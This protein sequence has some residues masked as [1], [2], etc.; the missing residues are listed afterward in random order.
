IWEFRQVADRVWKEIKPMANYALFLKKELTAVGGSWVKKVELDQHLQHLYC[1]SETDVFCYDMDGNQ[2]FKLEG[3]HRT[4]IT[5]CRY[6]LKARLLVTSSADAE[7]KVWSLTGGLVTTLRGH[8]KAITNQLLHPESSSLVM[9]SSLD[10]TVR[11]WSLDVME[12][13]YV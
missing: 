2:L 3:A 9:T 7:V 13:L 5:G 10:G 8:A 6:S 1:C 12:C 11:V 4:T